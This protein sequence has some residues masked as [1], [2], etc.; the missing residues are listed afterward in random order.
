MSE[1]TDLTPAELNAIRERLF[2]WYGAITA[3]ALGVMAVLIAYVIV[4]GMGFAGPGLASPGGQQSVGFAL[5][6]LLLLA[7]L[8][9]HLVDR[10]YRV[11]PFGRKV[12]VL[13]PRPLTIE[14]QVLLLKVLVAVF[15][16]AGIGWLIAGLLT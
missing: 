3:I 11:W 4:Y 16:A 15:A 1:L 9:V 13:V 5:A 8:L 10:I 14:S 2:R 6:M 7:A 12:E